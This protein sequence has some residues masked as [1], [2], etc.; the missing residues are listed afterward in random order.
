MSQFDPVQQKE[1]LAEGF[2]DDGEEGA[3][4]K[5][6]GVLQ[7]MDVGNIM[8]IV[9][10]WNSGV[11]I[12]AANLSGGEVFRMITERARELLAAIKQ[13]LQPTETES[14]VQSFR[15]AEELRIKRVSPPRA[16][17]AGSPTNSTLANDKLDE[18]IFAFFKRNL[19]E[20]DM[21]NA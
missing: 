18:Q 3:G 10:T 5:L 15:K 20:T 6:L 7:K 9:C 11:N 13:G 14:A 2:D 12:G 19:T 1:V 16:V 4:E 21:T 8:V 17:M